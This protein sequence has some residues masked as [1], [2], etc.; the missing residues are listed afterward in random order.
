MR[1]LIPTKKHFVL[2]ILIWF[3][4]WSIDT[5]D[6]F[7]SSALIENNAELQDIVDSAGAKIDEEVDE[8][9]DSKEDSYL[10]TGVILIGSEF[11]TRI[12]LIYLL[13]SLIVFIMN[14]TPDEEDCLNSLHSNSD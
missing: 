2:M 7:F 14:N 6:D 9:S 5:L 12:I 10:M 11:F 3:C 1:Y 4:F 8:A 13:S